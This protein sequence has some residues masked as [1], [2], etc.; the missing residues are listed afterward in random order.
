MLFVHLLKNLIYKQFVF[1]LQNNFVKIYFKI[2][3]PVIFLQCHS[4]LHDF[5]SL[6]RMCFAFTSWSCVRVSYRQQLFNSLLNVLP[7]L[8]EPVKSIHV[9]KVGMFE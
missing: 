2:L 6:I 7:V 8:E 3:D 5:H 1:K 4:I 9:L